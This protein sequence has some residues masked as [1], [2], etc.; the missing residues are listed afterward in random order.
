LNFTG[1]LLC[2]IT[3]RLSGWKATFHNCSHCGSLWRSLCQG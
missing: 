1:V 3:L 2:E